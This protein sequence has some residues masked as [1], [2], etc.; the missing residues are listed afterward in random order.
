MAEL[1][2]DKG[3]T[4]LLMADFHTDSMGENPIV[5]ERQTFERAKEVLEAARAAGVFV[6]YIVV[7]FRPGFPEISDLNQTFSTRKTSGQS[8]ALNPLDLIHPTV[9]PQQDEPVIVKHRVNAFFGTDLDVILRSQ[10]VDTLILMGHATSGVILSTVRYAADADYQLI[11]IEDGC[12]DR[13]P[14]VHTLLMEKIFPRQAVV[15]SSKD[16]VAAL[17]AS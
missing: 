16:A 6:A 15:T 3:K 4:A 9:P 7:N 17:A 8:P 13:D 10:G 14:E 11:V 1:K 5:R 12:A 2:L